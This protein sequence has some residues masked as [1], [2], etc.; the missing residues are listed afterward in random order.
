ML[1]SNRANEL[2]LKF[3]TLVTSVS[4]ISKARIELQTRTREGSQRQTSG[5]IF[6][7]F[8]KFLHKHKLIASHMVFQQRT[9]HLK[10]AT[11]TKCQWLATFQ[12]NKCH[13]HMTI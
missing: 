11:S 6:G 2:H 9:E 1:S 3:P 4:I 8:W 10:S 5:Q 13:Y 12:T 7:V